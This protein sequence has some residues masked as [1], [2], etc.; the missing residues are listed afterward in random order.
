MTYEYDQ[1]HDLWLEQEV[2]GHT[3]WTM[4]ARIIGDDRGVPVVA[5]LRIFPMPSK[6][7]S[8]R[9]PGEWAADTVSSHTRFIPR[10]GISATLVRKAVASGLQQQRHT[11]SGLRVAQ[12]PNPVT[13]HN[14]AVTPAIAATAPKSQDSKRRP[15][16]PV[17]WTRA[18]C[19]RIALTYDNA[20][21][22]HVSPIQAVMH[23]HHLTRTQARNLIAR[24]RR[25]DLIR[26]AP[27]AGATAEPLSNDQ[28]RQLETVAFD[29]KGSD[30]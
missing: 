16:R 12:S 27:R 7:D 3:G 5:E 6:K 9:A 28:R 2:P 22:A 4:A 13:P 17:K 29:W 25:Q 20:V 10:G 21:R 11:A 18:R 24:A 23:A 1:G 8:G 26:R 14:L 19:A 15:G 30:R